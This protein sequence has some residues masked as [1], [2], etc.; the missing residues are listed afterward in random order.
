M[1]ERLLILAIEAI[2]PKDH[3]IELLNSLS[4]IVSNSVFSKEVKAA[5][6]VQMALMKKS[7]ERE[8]R[9]FELKKGEYV[10]PSKKEKDESVDKV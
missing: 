8:S 4:M 2:D 9:G 7:I 5:A 1:T 10:R 3:C 6:L